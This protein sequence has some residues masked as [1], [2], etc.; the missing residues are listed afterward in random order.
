MTPPVNARPGERLAKLVAPLQPAAFRQH[1]WEKRARLLRAPGRS[2]DDL[3][4]TYASV[5]AAVAEGRAPAR[6]VTT[7]GDDDVTTPV[8]GS[9]PLPLPDR[10]TLCVNHVQRAFPALDA[11]CRDLQN[12]FG[13]VG[14]AFCNL[15]WSAAGHGFTGHFDTQAVFVVQLAGKK[16]WRFGPGP[17][18][19]WPPLGCSEAPAAM[20]DFRA[21]YPTV[22]LAG[23]AELDE[24]LLEPGDVLFL[25]AGTWHRA[26]AAGGECLA[27]AV[28]LLPATA[29][30]L[31]T[32]IVEPHLRVDL[33]WRRDLDAPLDVPVD[34]LPAGVAAHLG[35]RIEALRG[36]LAAITPADLHR[37][38]RLERGNVERRRWE[39]DTLAPEAE[40]CHAGGLAPGYQRDGDTIEVIHGGCVVALD[41][42]AEPFVRALCLGGRFRA[43]DAVA[44]DPELDWDEVADLLSTLLREGVLE[45]A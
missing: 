3:G 39:G 19:P 21:Q 17:D 10:S 5:A 38:F 4:V 42:A 23:P 16:L 33:G 14:V 24:V 27:L 6:V 25:P 45:I 7:E 13:L 1:V 12:G 11:L 41:A 35:E 40:I 26:R 32:K 8:Y 28:T 37:A 22:P 18:V 44:W 20:A 15:Y 2:W 36:L 29:W 31:I 30:D 34:G 43:S 9:V